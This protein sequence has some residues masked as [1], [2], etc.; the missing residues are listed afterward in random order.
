MEVH[1]DKSLE[2]LY[3]QDSDDEINDQDKNKRT[4]NFDQKTTTK[5]I[6]NSIIKYKIYGTITKNDGTS[7]PIEIEVN[8]HSRK[9]SSLWGGWGWLADSDPPPTWP[10]KEITW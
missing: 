5:I 9:R 8:E 7:F 3:S 4:Q 10:I 6:I 1:S 2:F